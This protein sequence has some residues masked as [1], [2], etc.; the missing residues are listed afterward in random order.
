MTPLTH[1]LP[2]GPVDLPPAY[3]HA[4]SGSVRFSVLID[5]RPMGAS[6]PSR[7][8]HYRFRPDG[9]DEDPLETYRGHVQDIA[10]AVRRR[11]AEGS[12]EPVILREFDL[13]PGAA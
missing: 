7:V 6:I 12:I 8:L 4:D 2:G 1:D 3:F 9:R 10:A 5:G 11:V 13:R